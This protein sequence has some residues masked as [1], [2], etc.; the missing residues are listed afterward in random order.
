MISSDKNSL[1]RSKNKII[2][3]LSLTFLLST[4][5]WVQFFLLGEIPSG[6]GLIG[7]GLMWS[8]GIAAII[9]KIVFDRNLR[10]MGWKWGKTHFVLM[11]YILPVI[12]FSLIYIPIWLFGFAEFSSEYL[13][14]RIA[15]A[16][17]LEK[18]ISL[19][20]TILIQSTLGLLTVIIPALGEEIGWRGL[21]VPELAKRISFTKMALV[22]GGIWAIW[23]YPMMFLGHS[24]ETNMLQHIVFYTVKL[25][26][27]SFIISWLVLKSGS[28]WPAVFMHASG[29]LFL[30]GVSNDLTVSNN[31]TRILLDDA[32]FGVVGV[33][34]IF[35]YVFW[36]K[37]S[38]IANSLLKI[39]NG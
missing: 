14:S 31:I 17:G 29:N 33:Y 34:I 15:D 3:F 30:E 39:T 16:V 22:V 18:P 13:T 36:R 32:G 6:G 1:K 12:V 5:F 19:G 21:L 28:I 24:E 10:G 38:E 4:V 26:A 35:A 27:Y 25:L 7:L 23:H 9:T 8:P 20:L 11:G 2:T 37:K